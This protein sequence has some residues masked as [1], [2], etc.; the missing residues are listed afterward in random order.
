M[1][2]S[3]RLGELLV[4][5]GLVTPQDVEAALERQK[6]EPGRIGTH[7]VAMGAVAKKKLG[8][9]LPGLLRWQAMHGPDHPNEHRARYSYARA[10][11]AAGHRAEALRNAE[12]ALSGYHATVGE[13]HA[14]TA[15]V[16][17]L[18]A[19]AQHAV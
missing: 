4:I 16:M 12:E 13:K 11:L 5:Q 1:E 8:S 3:M 2:T 18:I 17:N 10:L 14:W 6:Q 9:V 19:Q 7:L 15:E